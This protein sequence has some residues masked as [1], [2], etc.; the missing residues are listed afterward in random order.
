MY[1]DQ[2]GE[3]G[4]LLIALAFEI[5]RTSA[6]CLGRDD[7]IADL[8]DTGKIRVDGVHRSDNVVLRRLAL[9]GYSFRTGVEALRQRS[10]GADD[11][12][13]LRLI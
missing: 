6:V 9:L 8:A 7:L 3:R 10:C 13:L 5:R 11:G 12:G 2:A 1:I 4:D